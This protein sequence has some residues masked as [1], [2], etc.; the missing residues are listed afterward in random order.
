MVQLVVDVVHVF[1]AG[2]DVTVYAEMVL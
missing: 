2:V 1:E